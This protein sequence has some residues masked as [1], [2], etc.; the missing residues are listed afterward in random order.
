MQELKEILDRYKWQQAEYSFHGQQEDGGH[1]CQIAVRD[2][3]IQ[4]IVSKPCQNQRSAKS[5]AASQALAILVE[6]KLA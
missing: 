1:I 6:R 2:A 3:G 4:G 5:S